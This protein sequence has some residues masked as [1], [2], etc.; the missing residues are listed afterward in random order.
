MSAPCP[1]CGSDEVEKV[2]L[3]AT[4]QN[5]IRCRACGGQGPPASSPA[6]AAM[7]WAQRPADLT[8]AVKP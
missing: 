5:A 2:A 1:F 8:L 7:L 3:N 4:W 6:L